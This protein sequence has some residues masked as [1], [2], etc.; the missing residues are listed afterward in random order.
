MTSARSLFNDGS[1]LK[2]AVQ[3]KGRLT[4]HSMSLLHQIGLNF[5]SYGQRLF[6]PVRNFPLSLLYARDDDIPGYVTLNTVDLGIVGK[7]LV[8]EYEADVEI[9]HPLGF[10]YCELVI[11]VPNESEVQTPE[12]L[13]NSRIATSY[14]SSTRRY[15]ESIGGN[16]EIITVSGSVEITPALDIADA[17]VDLAAT[18]SSL[19]LNDLRPIHSILESEAILIANGEAL[20]DPGR[21]ENIDRLLMRIKAV[22]AAEQYKYVMMNAH[23]DSLPAIR[24]VIP[25]LKAPTIVP[26]ADEGWYAV[27]T[28]IREEDFWKKIEELRAAGASEILVSALDKLL[29]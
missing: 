17:I 4:E 16:P 27:H 26:L 6:S 10:G 14:P 5:E 23:A 25:G 2:L 11:A 1:T 19:Q 18:G 13:R 8:H 29:L 15:F 28:A 24:K 3:R 21:R 22:E 7:N 9:I 12:D 20:G